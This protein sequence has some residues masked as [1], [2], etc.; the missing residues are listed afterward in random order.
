MQA[1]S[2]QGVDVQEGAKSGTLRWGE[3]NLRTPRQPRSSRVLWPTCLEPLVSRPG[4]AS[5]RASVAPPSLWEPSPILKKP[6]KVYLKASACDQC[7]AS[8]PATTMLDKC[9]HSACV[10]R[11]T[12]TSNPQRVNHGW[13][14]FLKTSIR[15]P[16][17][18]VGVDLL[19]Q[20]LWRKETVPCWVR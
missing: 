8:L 5:V 7:A 14:Q 17:L 15:V 12:P 1:A 3:R 6:R 20:P 11:L 10:G 16:S 2:Q 13:F 19:V 4:Q 18:S 9:M